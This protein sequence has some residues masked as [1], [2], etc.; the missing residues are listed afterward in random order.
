MEWV[1][2]KFTGKYRSMGLKSLVA[3]KTG[4][5]LLKPMM[6]MPQGD[7]KAYRILQRLRDAG[8]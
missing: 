6:Y 1:P 7:T 8:L 3:D 4:K 2:E 5:Q